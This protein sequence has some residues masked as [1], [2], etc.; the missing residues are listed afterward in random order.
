MLGFTVYHVSKNA[1][2]R[3]EKNG[4]KD[5]YALERYGNIIIFEKNG[6][7]KNVP[8][9]E[10]E[11]REY[12][13]KIQKRRVKA[14]DGAEGLFNFCAQEIGADSYGG[15]AKIMIDNIFEYMTI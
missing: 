2:G 3:Y 8:V 12:V 5:E 13:Y 11:S 7:K 6:V 1:S 15:L 14:R 9:I 4:E 10:D